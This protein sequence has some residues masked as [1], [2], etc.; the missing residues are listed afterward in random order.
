MTP[1]LGPPEYSAYGPLQVCA[2]LYT[3]DVASDEAV[4]IVGDIVRI[5]SDRELMAIK[6]HAAP[7]SS[8]ARTQPTPILLKNGLKAERF[9]QPTPDATKALIY[10]SN[11]LK[12]EDVRYA[13][14]LS[15]GQADKAILAGA[16]SF[17][18][19]LQ[20]RRLLDRIKPAADKEHD[21]IQPEVAASYNRTGSGWKA[22][23]ARSS[24]LAN[25]Y[26]PSPDIGPFYYCYGRLGFPMRQSEK[27]RRP[28]RSLGTYGPV[29]VESDGTA[30]KIQGPTENLKRIDPNNRKEHPMGLLSES[31]I[32]YYPSRG[33]GPPYAAEG[34]R[35]TGSWAVKLAPN[36]YR[37]VEISLPASEKTDAGF[38]FL[39]RLEFVDDGDP[40]CG[41][42]GEAQ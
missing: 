24:Y 21:C 40:R 31:A 15:T 17:N 12:P 2:D 32:A 30:I 39:E 5:I 37:G 6:A 35:E 23:D 25:I 42:N 18:G 13:I 3:V 7:A 9:T 34:V 33:I 4:H 22:A 36:S 41:K 1:P 26:P 28:W 27:L 16:T 8:F 11:G 10:A 20:D 14:T 19:T 29:V 38:S